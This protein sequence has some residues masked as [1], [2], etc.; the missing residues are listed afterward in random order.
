ML[1][2]NND[3]VWRVACIITTRFQNIINCI[4]LVKLHFPGQLWQERLSV[5]DQL[6]NLVKN[7]NDFRCNSF[8]YNYIGVNRCVVSPWQHAGHVPPDHPRIKRSGIGHTRYKGH[9]SSRFPE[10][11]HRWKLWLSLLSNIPHQNCPMPTEPSNH[12]PISW[13]RGYTLCLI[14]I[15]KSEVRSIIHCLRLGHET[16]VSAVCFSIFL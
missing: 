13:L 16:M 6:Q 2:R 3:Q 8:V 9:A 14:I 10:I 12:H 1:N 5:H 11:M 4:L 7:F 15:I